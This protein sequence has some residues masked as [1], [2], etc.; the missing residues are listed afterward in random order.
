MAGGAGRKNSTDAAQR[1]PTSSYHG[2][3]GRGAWIEIPGA[4]A[5][6]G[7]FVS[8]AEGAE[9]EWAATLRSALL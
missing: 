8:A 2:C 1:V 3:A 4:G 6:A 7:T 9:I 5:A